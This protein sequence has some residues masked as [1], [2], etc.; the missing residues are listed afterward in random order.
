MQQ[1]NAPCSYSCFSLYNMSDYRTLL[2]PEYLE[3]TGKTRWRVIKD[4]FSARG[5]T[6]RKELVKVRDT[7]QWA[8]DETKLSLY[9]LGT[10]QAVNTALNSHNLATTQ[11]VNAVAAGAGQAESCA[12]EEVAV[13]RQQVG[14]SCQARARDRKRREN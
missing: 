3:L 12:R 9:M 11:F 8:D 7:W 5:A 14:P 10:K 4:I 13:R 1:Y 6:E 2:S